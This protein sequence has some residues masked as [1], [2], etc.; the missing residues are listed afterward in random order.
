[1][2]ILPSHTHQGSASSSSFSAPQ[3]PNF[4]DG[5]SIEFDGD[6][7]QQRLVHPTQLS[8]SS[9]IASL[10]ISDPQSSASMP[11]SVSGSMVESATGSSGSSQKV[12]EYGSSNGMKKSSNHNSNGVVQPQFVARGGGGSSS[13]NREVCG[14]LPNRR[15]TGSAGRRPQTVNANHLLNFQYNPI[16]RPQQRAPPL[17]KPQKV[18]PYNKDLFLQA[19][20]KFIVLD[21]G[22]YSTDSMDPDKTLQ[23]E[24]I[25]CVKYSTPHLIQCPICLDS[26]LC[27]QITSCGHI[28]CFPCILQYLLMGVENHKTD[29]QRKCPL[30]FVMMSSKDLYTICIDNVKEHNV[31]DV[32]EFTLLTRKKDSFSLYEK[33]NGGM[34]TKTSESFSKFILTSDVDLSVREAISDL[35]NWL[36]R[37]DSGLV[38]DLERLPYVC[39]AMEQLRQRQ[40]SWNAHRN[41]EGNRSCKYLN[42][43]SVEVNLNCEAYE[44]GHETL[45]PGIH[46]ANKG[47]DN[48]TSDVLQGGAWLFQSCDTD[49]SLEGQDGLLCSSYDERKNSQFQSDASRDSKERDSYH[50]YQAVDGQHIILHPLNMKC[51][52]HHYGSYDLLPARLSGKILQLE[53]VTQSEAMRRRYRYLSHFP[54]TTTFQLCEIDLREI[55][56][57]DALSPFMDEIKKRAKHRKWLAKKEHDNK[58][59]ADAIAAYSLPVPYNMVQG[60]FDG[61]P[62]FSMDDFEALGSPTSVASSPPVQGGRQLFSNVARLG[63]AAAYDS[64][65]LNNEVSSVPSVERATNSGGL[66]GSV[67][68]D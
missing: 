3:N 67:C 39:A 38:D 14:S 43:N 44:A 60:S 57:P 19:N 24:D 37:A 9:N 47:T 42:C 25:I 7:L 10:R 26:P 21:S 11:N 51:L 41:S 18:K 6:L 50:F 13:H 36:A 34:N 58:I 28:F 61:L 64:P 1:M 33:T 31:G 8:P 55:L 32:L 63:F 66:I 17:R 56:P 65:S 4:D 54:L 15:V 22:S 62:T 59:K 5:L 30:C 52:L 29:C 49:A 20:Y 53:S 68:F 23:W 48:V 46:D 2:S 45:S 27:P 40:K 12:N 16:G 35:D